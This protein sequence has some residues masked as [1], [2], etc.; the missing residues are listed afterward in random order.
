MSTARTNQLIVFKK[1]ADDRIGVTI[2][3]PSG[4]RSSGAPASS[5]P[6]DLVTQELI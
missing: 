6:D 4:E 1:F 3:S 2:F 5:A